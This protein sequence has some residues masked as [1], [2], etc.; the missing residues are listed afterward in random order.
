MVNYLLRGQKFINLNQK[1]PKLME[2]HCVY[3]AFQRNFFFFVDNM[4]KTEFYG[5]V[6]DFIVDYDAIAVDDILDIRKYW[7]KKYGIVLIKCLDLLK[8]C[9]L[10]QQ[11]D[12]LVA[13]H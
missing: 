7:M 12:V 9:F 10:L 2:F 5:F 8:E 3:E 6:Y 13:V 11:G 1:S 4:R